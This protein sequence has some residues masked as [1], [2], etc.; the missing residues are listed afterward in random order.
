MA[1]KKKACQK[2]QPLQNV[3]TD[4]LTDYLTKLVRHFSLERAARDTKSA[5]LACSW[6]VK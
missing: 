5:L 6:P 4:Q 3:P 1:K 2:S